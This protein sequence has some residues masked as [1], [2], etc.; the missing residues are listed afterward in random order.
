M[1]E[2]GGRTGRGD[3]LRA[4]GGRAAESRELGE[5]ASVVVSAGGGG[6]GSRWGDGLR[7]LEEA[8]WGR[9]ELLER[10]RLQVKVG[11]VLPDRQAG[12]LMMIVRTYS[13]CIAKL[14]SI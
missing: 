2:R 7:R 6:P 14:L 5:S 9:E 8:E 12:P 3:A 4:A 11:A 1:D 10:I 13:T